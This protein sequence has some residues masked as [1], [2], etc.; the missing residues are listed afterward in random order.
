M[1]DDLGFGSG[2]GKSREEEE[3]SREAVQDKGNPRSRTAELGR[4]FI[5]S[6]SFVVV[7]FV[8]LTLALTFP[9]VFHLTSH[10]PGDLGDP[11]YNIWVMEDNVRKARGGFRDFW[12]GRIF[13]PHGDTKLYADTLTALS[14]PY[15]LLSAATGNAVLAYNIILLF[16][17]VFSASGMALLVKHLTQSR[18]AA[19]LAG[20]MFAFFPYRFAHIW[21]LELLYFA[22]IPFC[23]YF[24]L[25]YFEAHNGWDLL[26]TGAMFVLQAL[27]CAYYGLY[28]GVVLLLALFFFVPKS[29]A[30]RRLSFW[31]QGAAIAV[32]CAAALLPVFLPYVRAHSRM[33]FERSVGDVEAHSA[34]L[35]HFLAVPPSNLVWGRWTGRWGDQETQLFPGIV[36]L[37]WAAASFLGRRPAKT[38]RKRS[39][40]LMIWDGLNVALLILALVVYKTGG[41]SLRWGILSFSS[42]RLVNI[43]VFLAVSALARLLVVR[44]SRER[45][46]RSF[47][48]SPISPRTIEGQR[49]Q[50]RFYVILAAASFVLALGPQ[51]RWMG[52]DVITGPFLA[53]YEWIPGFRSVRVP[54][55]FVVFL[56]TGL[57]VLAGM[58]IARYERWDRSPGRRRAVLAATGFVLLAE[59]ISVPVPLAP[60]PE[61]GSASSIYE[62]VRRLPGNTVLVELPM[63]LP[64]NPKATEAVYMFHS[65]YHGK[66]LLNGYSGFIPP[67]AVISNLAMNNFP[68]QLSLDY[69][70]ALGVDYVLVHCRGFRP[71]TGQVMTEMLVQFPLRIQLVAQ[72]GNDYLYR[73]RLGGSAVRKAAADEDV[74]AR[75]LWV[76]WAGRNTSRTKLAFDR[77]LETGW[78]TDGPQ[79][80]KDFFLLDL[81]QMERFDRLELFLNRRPLE[82]PRGFTLSVSPDNREWTVVA[83]CPI[84]FPILRAEMIERF[85]EYKTEVEFDPVSARYLKI[86][87]ATAHPTRPWSIQEIALSLRSTPSAKSSKT[88]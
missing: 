8:F 55:R 86:Y 82:F 22:W 1:S 76:G 35:Q 74:G 39:P 49:F 85:E 7:L 51:I 37:L 65:L 54:S 2:E 42:H 57:A 50:R 20:A 21:H 11:L 69:L 56:M 87:A 15:G 80:P 45:L 43:I 14:V 84:H 78:S 58:A 63:P 60:V 67:A 40:G 4:R 34:E 24:L 62:E 68:S 47:L 83:D 46:F 81:G 12:D 26:W 32:L 23:L 29:G 13:Y 28:L 19:V 18:T 25:R 59:S 53:L 27:S 77:D 71:R 17:F 10:V 41:F 66:R 64:A 38:R 44:S 5:R 70:E 48:P 9:L 3:R 73:L 72:Y 33:E 16:S 6:R 75:S 79:R 52:R 30:W 31:R 36:I 88:P 61:A